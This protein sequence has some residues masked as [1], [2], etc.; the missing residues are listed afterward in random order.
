[1][2]PFTLRKIKSEYREIVFRLVAK[3]KISI[4]SIS[5]LLRKPFKTTLTVFLK[6][7]SIDREIF[8]SRKFFRGALILPVYHDL[9][10]KIYITEWD[11]LHIGRREF[12]KLSK[13]IRLKIKYERVK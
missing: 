5:V 9:V 11:E 2:K 7:L 4:S 12:K 3:E 6:L 1:M 13:L 8:D 10:I